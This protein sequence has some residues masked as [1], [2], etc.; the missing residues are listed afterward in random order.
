MKLET[1]ARAAR[2]IGV[3]SLILGLVTVARAQDPDPCTCEKGHACYH[4]LNSPVDAPEGDCWC[5]ACDRDAPHAGDR[6]PPGWNRECFTSRDMDCFLKRHAAS[7]NFTCSACLAED[8]CC[9]RS[10]PDRCPECQEGGGKGP[11]PARA[12]EKM[13]TRMHV[14]QKLFTGRR[15]VIIQSRNFHL[16]T[17]IARVKVRTQKGG[18]I[19]TTTG[20]EYAHVMLA[21]AESA[22]REFSEAV[23]RPRLQAKMGIYLTATDRTAAELKR[24]YFRSKTADMIYSSYGSADESGISEGYCF[25]GFCIS[26]QK[27]RGDDRRMHVSL[28]HFLGHVAVTCWIRWNGENRTMPRWAFIGTAH[29]LGRRPEELRQEVEFCTSEGQ[30]LQGDGRQWLVDLRRLNRSSKLTPIEELLAK[31]SMG[32]FTMEEHKQLWGYFHFAMS[33]WREP[34]V[35][36]LGDLRN[37]REVHEALHDRLGCTPEEFH[38]LFVARLTG[39]RPSIDPSSART[40]AKPG[41]SSAAATLGRE[42]DPVKIAARI[43]AFGKPSDPSTVRAILDA[44]GNAGSDLVRET[45]FASLLH[46]RGARAREAIWQHGLGHSDKLVRAHAARLVRALRLKAAR[47]SL[48]TALADPFW[49]VRSESAL[50]LASIRDRRDEPAV[51]ALVAD[52]SPKVRIG[53]MDALRM[54]RS[55]VHRDAVPLLVANVDHDAWQVRVAACQALAEL[56]DWRALESLISRMENE[57]GRVREEIHRALKAITYD[58][59]GRKPRYWR[60]WWEKEREKT[61]RRGGFEKPVAPRGDAHYGPLDRPPTYHGVELF[62]ARLGFALD[63]SL[64]THREFTPDAETAKRLLGTG[65]TTNVLAICKQ[66]ITRSIRSLDPRTHLGIVVFNDRVRRWKKSMVPAGD[67]NRTSALS[68]LRAQVPKGETNFYEALRAMLDME[69]ASPF[70]PRFR[71]TPDTIVFLTDGSPTVGEIT[72]ADTLLHWYTALNR[73]ARIRTHTIAFG[74]LGVDEPLLEA[75]AK[76]NDGTF[77]Q[78]REYKPR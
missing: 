4:F 39:K 25:N 8:K 69:G 12:H 72:D 28:R 33:E 32:R 71:R 53:A 37:E 15:P 50:A 22:Y 57:A 34:F 49:L 35:K 66:E 31:T 74:A 43:R 47:P 55:S 48:K 65:E 44:T 73:Y 29:W 36:M 41:P 61:V 42:R 6:V 5:R 64:S 1:I 18:G 2:W 45:A 70:D 20:H 75:L 9:K 11:W 63:V 24:R 56:G 62:S 78:I 59:L 46:A 7:W 14:E 38:R 16:V 77:K 51:R 19:R 27:S 10:H 67:S 40:P 23:D 68:F 58:D 54:Y 13:A 30:D 76:R 17:D 26:A 21:R 60:A 52:K 3:A